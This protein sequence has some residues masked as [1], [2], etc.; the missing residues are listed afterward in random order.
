MKKIVELL[1]HT[2]NPNKQNALRRNNAG[3]MERNR[4]KRHAKHKGKANEDTG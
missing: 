4:Y 2:P 3:V 1:K